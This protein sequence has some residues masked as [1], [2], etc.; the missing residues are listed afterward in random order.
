MQIEHSSLKQLRLKGPKFAFFLLK[1]III[2]QLL[3]IE[4]KIFKQTR[5]TKHLVL[6]QKLN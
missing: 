6:K 3:F 2:Y 5:T 4:N 1:V